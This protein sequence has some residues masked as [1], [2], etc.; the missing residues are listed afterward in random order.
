MFQ[1]LIFVNQTPVS[2][3]N[4]YFLLRPINLDFAPLKQNVK[5]FLVLLKPRHIAKASICHFINLS[6]KSAAPIIVNPLS[7]RHSL[8]GFPTTM[9]FLT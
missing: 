5:K 3:S 4:I 9:I 7:S 1:S 8:I 2:I 6:K